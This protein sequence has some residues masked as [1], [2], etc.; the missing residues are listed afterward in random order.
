MMSRSRHLDLT[1]AETFVTPGRRQH[2]RRC[3]AVEEQLAGSVVHDRAV[4]ASSRAGVSVSR[5]GRG[6]A[7]P[8]YSSTM[9]EQP[10]CST[11]NDG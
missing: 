7:I 11:E 10:G 9:R 8:V 2:D 6:P 3:A 5:V 4:R 1:Q